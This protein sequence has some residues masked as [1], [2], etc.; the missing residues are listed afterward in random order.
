[1]LAILCKVCYNKDVDEIHKVLLG[2][3]VVL[4]DENKG[5]IVMFNLFN[6]SSVL[7]TEVISHEKKIAK[8]IARTAEFKVLFIQ[9]ESNFPGT[10]TRYS[11][12]IGD[13]I[14]EMARKLSELFGDDLDHL[15][16]IKFSDC[17]EKEAYDRTLP[18]R[19]IL[20]ESNNLTKKQKQLLWEHDMRV[21]RIIL[22]ELREIKKLS[23]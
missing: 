16:G 12:L 23:D 14:H 6:E 4:Q 8:K 13:R 3:Q 1:M 5:G 19:R 17:F 7:P 9:C 2:Q 20:I 21:V 10:P 18:V 11:V 22:R 15:T